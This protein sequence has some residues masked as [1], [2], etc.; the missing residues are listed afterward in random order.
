MAPSAVN[1]SA[2][3]ESAADGCLDDFLPAAGTG[4]RGGPVMQ[5][6]IDGAGSIP[7]RRDARKLPE[8]PDQMSLIGIAGSRGNVTETLSVG[9]RHPPHREVEASY[10]IV[11]LGVETDRRAK[12]SNEMSRAIARSALHV[13]NPHLR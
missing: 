7:G 8:F 3:F 1:D 10:P 9:C 11:M 2:I 6:T 5:R 12:Q 13:R 4:L